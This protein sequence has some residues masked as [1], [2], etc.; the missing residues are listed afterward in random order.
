LRTH[1]TFRHPARFVPV[2][3]EDGVL[4]VAGAAWFVSLLGHVAD[5]RLEQDLCQEDWGVVVFAGRAGKK[6]WIGLSADGEGAWI[7][8]F[9]HGARAWLQRVTASG[10]RE[11]RRLMQDLHGVLTRD[12][13]VSDVAWYREDEMTRGQAGSDSPG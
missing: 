10:G 8:H 13:A 6:F 3:E 2:S 4:S 9:H 1:A 5:L 7:V 11:L 12:P